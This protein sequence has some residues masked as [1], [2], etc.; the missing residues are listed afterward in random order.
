MN[1]IELI[2]V[3]VAYG[4]YRALAGVSLAVPDG[5]LIALIGPNGAGKSTVARVCAGLVVPRSGRFLVG[6][7]EMTGEPK[8][9]VSRRGVASLPEGGGLFSGLSV[10]ENLALTFRRRLGRP[11]VQ[12]AIEQVFERFPMLAERRRQPAGT[13]SG[14]Q[15]RLL[16]LAKVLGGSPRVI[17]ADE[18]SLGL[19]P[20]AADDV[21]EQLSV[22][23]SEG[24]ALLVIEQQTDR[25]LKLADRAVVLDRG[26]VV[27]EGNPGSGADVL[28]S[29]L[30]AGSNDSKEGAMILDERCGA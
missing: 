15:Q 25:V 2:S 30:R 11:K 19:S 5:S 22:L 20:A 10:E 28:S 1:A 23:H 16:A 3:D 26:S 17:V 4:P 24:R 21:Y 13:L 7:K 9:L 18:L 6:G 12:P 29:I 8:W 14:G 27:F